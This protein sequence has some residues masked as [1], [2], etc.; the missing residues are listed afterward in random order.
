[1]V[2]LELKNTSLNLNSPIKYIN[3]WKAHYYPDK[4]DSI[5]PVLTFSHV[6]LDALM[7][8]V[9]LLRRIKH[10]QI[11]NDVIGAIEKV[12]DSTNIGVDTKDLFKNSSFVQME[13]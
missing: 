5:F 1:M 13:E 8:Y 10:N 7:F 6:G 11:F 3:I 2:P 9:K 12:H 4:V